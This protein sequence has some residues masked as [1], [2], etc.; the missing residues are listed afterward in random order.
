MSC[1][2]STSASDVLLSLGTIV[3]LMLNVCCTD[4][5]AQTFTKIT[6]NVNLQF[7]DDIEDVS[8][9]N[10]RSLRYVSSAAFVSLSFRSIS[11]SSIHSSCRR[12]LR[13]QAAFEVS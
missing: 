11:S 7:E 2:L 5:V 10:T 3:G 13:E 4:D 6:T 12:M 8:Y 1:P 9:T